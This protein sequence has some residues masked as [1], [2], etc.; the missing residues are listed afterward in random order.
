MPLPPDSPTFRQLLAPSCTDAAA[1]RAGAAAPSVAS[2]QPGSSSLP[3]RRTISAMS[4]GG[5]TLGGT[6]GASA[7]TLAASRRFSK[8]P[9]VSTRAG[10]RRL[11]GVAERARQHRARTTRRH[12]TG[13]RGD[14]RPRRPQH[15]VGAPR[16]GARASRIRDRDQRPA[17]HP[18]DGPAGSIGGYPSVGRVCGAT[19]PGRRPGDVS[20]RGVTG[21][22]C[23]ARRHG[24]GCGARRPPA[25]SRTRPTMSRS[26]KTAARPAGRLVAWNP[27]P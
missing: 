13:P 6:V 15:L 1:P 7:G 9:G 3:C 23:A 5:T 14:A 26:S 21:S 25:Q 19:E 12:A 2:A 4:S 16:P 22:I 11:R 8:P 10:P 27:Q 24:R 20:G 17:H 18:A